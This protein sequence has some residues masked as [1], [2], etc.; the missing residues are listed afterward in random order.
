MSADLLETLEIL[1]EL[2][3]DLIGENVGVLSVYDITLSVEE[4]V[5]NFAD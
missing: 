3:V 4:P 2:G 1:T 5:W